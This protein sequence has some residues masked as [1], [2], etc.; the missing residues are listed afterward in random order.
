MT[1]RQ[2]NRLPL[3][4]T[5]NS[6]RYPPHRSLHSCSQTK[7]AT[8][9]N[10]MKKS[11]ANLALAALFSLSAL[12][13][14]WV[15][16]AKDK[17]V[18]VQT[19][20]DAWYVRRSQLH[21]TIAVLN[22]QSTSRADRGRAMDDFDAR[23]TAAENGEYT[24]M[25]T[26]ELFRIFYVPKELLE[27]SPDFDMLLRITATQATLGWYDALRFTDESGRVEIENHERFFSLP[28]V[29]S[30]KKFIQYI[31]NHPEQAAAAV[32]TGIQIAFDKIKSN[33]IHYDTHWPTHYGMAR[34]KCMMLNAKTCKPPEPQPENKWP[35]LLDQAAQR[36]SAY[37]RAD[38]H[39]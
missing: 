35:V 2:N 12:T 13:T 31:E 19:R 34:M 26:M 15:A 9:E 39:K 5:Q 27:K 17:V 1:A 8:I 7:Q 23:L 11:F 24:P 3:Q 6:S 25:E 20:D 29:E 28:F 33:D 4:T 10:L 37:Y 22:E 36:V 32:Q 18:V 21:A 30:R 38:N 14:P 16:H